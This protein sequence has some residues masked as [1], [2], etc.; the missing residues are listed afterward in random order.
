MVRGW[1]TAGLGVFQ[2]ILRFWGIVSF[3]DR[4]TGGLFYG[5]LRA[6]W[7]IRVEK[8]QGFLEMIEERRLEKRESFWRVN[9]KKEKCG[10]TFLD[11]CGGNAPG[12]NPGANETEFRASPE[13]SF[14]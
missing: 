1:C 5:V 10:S 12:M 9:G 14:R 3:D 2:G 6:V 7:K 8:N 4:Q 13:V 11:R